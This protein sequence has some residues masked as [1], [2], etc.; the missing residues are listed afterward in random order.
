MARAYSD[1]T[2]AEFTAAAAL[3][4]VAGRALWRLEGVYAHAIEQLRARAGSEDVAVSK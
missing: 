3:V 4:D 2:E 1:P